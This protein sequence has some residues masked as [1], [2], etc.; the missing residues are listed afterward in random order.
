MARSIYAV[1]KHV[2]PCLHEVLVPRNNGYCLLDLVA[3]W[4]W[5]LAFCALPI[6][7]QRKSARMKFRNPSALS[8][9]FH[10]VGARAFFRLEEASQ[11]IYPGRGPIVITEANECWRRL[12]R[13][14]EGAALVM[15]V[16]ESCIVVVFGRELGIIGRNAHNDDWCLRSYSD[17]N[18][19]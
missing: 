6:E 1:M 3:N 18:K 10:A 12:W 7:R 19:P 14:P 2:E 11:S 9:C 5:V 17:E 8:M 4:G 15:G 16:A 13:H